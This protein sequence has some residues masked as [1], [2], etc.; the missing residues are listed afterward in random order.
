MTNKTY[1]KQLAEIFKVCKINKVEPIEIKFSDLHI[2]LGESTKPLVTLKS[3]TRGMRKKARQITEVAT[4]QE[5]FDASRE[6]TEIMHLEDPAGF[7]RA[8]I[9]GEL[10]EEKAN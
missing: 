1:A 3:Q 8:Y 6:L 2:V 4:L 9:E 5:D 10:G 7:E